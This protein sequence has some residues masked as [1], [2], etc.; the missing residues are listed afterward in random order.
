MLTLQLLYSLLYNLSLFTF[1]VGEHQKQLSYADRSTRGH[2]Q[3]TPTFLQLGYLIKLF[4]KFAEAVQVANCELK[5]KAAPTFT[6]QRSCQGLLYALHNICVSHYKYSQLEPSGHSSS[7]FIY[8]Y[9]TCFLHSNITFLY[10]QAKKSNM[11]KT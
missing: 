9:K 10:V 4:I 5:I 2:C 1:T 7:L 6:C 3:N 8:Q 11:Y